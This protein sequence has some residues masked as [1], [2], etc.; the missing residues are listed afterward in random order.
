MRFFADRPDWL[1]TVQ[2]YFVPNDRAP[3]PFAYSFGSQIYD[4][5]DLP[6]AAIG[7]VYNPHPY[8]QGDSALSRSDYRSLRQRRTN[9]QTVA[10]RPT[11]SRRS[12][13]TPRFQCAA[14]PCPW[15]SLGGLAWAA[16]DRAQS[17]RSCGYGP[18]GA[19]RRADS[20]KV[21]TP[22]PDSAVAV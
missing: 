5:K 6:E 4:R 21:P 7:E 22:P 12:G 3:L 16:T 14:A 13:P 18:M 15:R 20:G 17:P 10:S 9:G 8:R 11:R 2:W 1:T 19:F